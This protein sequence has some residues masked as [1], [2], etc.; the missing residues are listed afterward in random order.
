MKGLI[1]PLVIG[2]AL[3]MAGCTSGVVVTPSVDVPTPEVTETPTPEWTEEQQASIDAVQ[4]YITMWATIGQ[5]VTTAQWNDI[6][7]VAID[8]QSN[9]DMMLWAHWVDEG[10]HLTNGPRFTPASVTLGVND[11]V[12]QHFH[13][14]GC[15]V[16]EGS[17]IVDAT[18]QFIGE[19][20]RRERAATS[21]VV[22]HT[23]E[24]PY[25]VTDS[26][27]EGPSC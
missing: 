21:Y 23:H 14:R 9:H 17:H 26:T 12:G 4:A 7:T 2:V 27:S 10:W 16:I 22:L 20:T 6:L 13:V 3:T 1:L 11:E 19:E 8:P 5:N 25:L 15:Y 18:G 24:G